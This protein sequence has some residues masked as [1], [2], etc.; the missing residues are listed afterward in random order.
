MVRWNN[1]GESLTE[2]LI[3]ADPSPAAVEAEKLGY[4]SAGF[5]NWRKGKS[6]PVVART[7]KETGKLVP[8]K[9]ADADAKG[10]A[11]KTAKKRPSQRRP[12]DT[13]EKPKAPKPREKKPS[14]ED[15]VKAAGAQIVRLS[16]KPKSGVEGE[17]VKDMAKLV[18]NPSTANAEAF[19]KQYG[20]QTNA[21]GGKMY[22]D[23]SSA[24]K[25]SASA[26]MKLLGSAA[27]VT[28]RDWHML[29]KPNHIY[30][31]SREVIIEDA[32]E[33]KG[34]RVDGQT[35]TKVPDFK[36]TN[37]A[38]VLEET[39]LDP[40]EAKM[41]AT[42][43]VAASM[44]YNDRVDTLKRVGNVEVADYSKFPGR[45][46]SER[47]G[48]AVVS[49]LISAMKR[50]DIKPD[51]DTKKALSMIQQLSQS[52]N[53]K[54]FEARYVELD[55]FVEGGTSGIR[56]TM[57]LIAE[58]FEAMYQTINGKQALI[59]MD[60]SFATSDIIAF[61]KKLPKLE[62]VEDL[63]ALDDRIDFVFATNVSVK[64]RAGGA[65]SS[66]EKVRQTKFNSKRVAKDCER[67]ADIVPDAH[68]PEG[69]PSEFETNQ[70]LDWKKGG[71]FNKVGKELAGMLEQ[72]KNDLMEYYQFPPETTT[73]QLFDILSGGGR[74]IKRKG[75][76]YSKSAPPASWF[77]RKE[78]STKTQAGAWT[79][80]AWQMHNVSGFILEAIHNRHVNYQSYTNAAYKGNKIDRTDGV[81]KLSAMRFQPY[82]MMVKNAKL[83]TLVPDSAMSSHIVSSDRENMQTGV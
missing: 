54:E 27:S 57:P 35:I 77:G 52:K 14:G 9:G 34:I 49:G 32:G 60:E 18:K 20:I 48:S 62:S 66:I 59:P 1:L 50:G 3:E 11:E 24:F 26:I 70:I 43:L 5:G 36:I 19:I 67:L 61:A 6:G 65:S 44:K 25:T 53:V 74:P 45:N 2:F 28:V 21:D 15:L 23:H 12:P 51:E 42:D 10:D 72:H 82:K 47:I 29:V 13:E 4:T 22:S 38:K 64:F 73:E 46:D 31:D 33:G 71:P 55:S 40:N 75:M 56:K 39:G 7:D 58:Q 17:M 8:V 16:K 30:T 69:H 68:K 63:A 80:T 81:R 78:F 76:E 37:V 83:G 79:T 41:R